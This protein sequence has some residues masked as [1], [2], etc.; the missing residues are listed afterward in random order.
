ML[1]MVF[2]DSLG[3]VLGALRGFL[4]ALLVLLRALGGTLNFAKLFIWAPLR[5][6]LAPRGASNSPKRLPR[7]PPGEADGPTKPPRLIW[8]RIWTYFLLIS[9]PKSKKKRKQ[10]A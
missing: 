10:E 4:G 5:P 8:R 6:H 1:L 9:D 3:L 7:R 2:W